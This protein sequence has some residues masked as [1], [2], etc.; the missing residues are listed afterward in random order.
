MRCMS[1]RSLTN[2]HFCMNIVVICNFWCAFHDLFT[3][4]NRCQIGRVICSLFCGYLSIKLLLLHKWNTIIHFHFCCLCR[5]N[6]SHQEPT[7][8]QLYHGILRQRL[9]LMT[10]P[11]QRSLIMIKR[12]LPWQSTLQNTKPNSGTM[13]RI[14][15]KFLCSDALKFSHYRY[16]SV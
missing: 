11:N 14:S 9:I 7:P 6:A 12:I 15:S 8:Q 13:G 1:Y 5:F 4:W 10:M 2:V 16:V 3:K